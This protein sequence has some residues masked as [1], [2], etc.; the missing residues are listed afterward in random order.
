[1]PHSRGIARLGNERL[2]YTHPQS[3][4]AQYRAIF[5]HETYRFDLSDNQRSPFIIDCGAN[6]GVAVLYWKRLYPHATILTFEPDPEIAAVL[7]SNITA[8]GI[9]VEVNEAAVWTENG[10]RQFSRLGAGTGRFG[11][12]VPVSTVRLQD[13]LSEHVNLLK[14]DIEGAEIDVLTDCAQVLHN[15]DRIFVEFHSFVDRPQRLNILVDLLTSAGFRLFIET[16]F[17]PSPPFISTERHIDMDMQ[18]NIYARRIS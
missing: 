10:E 16:E 14:I 8:A 1:M 7:R 13:Y 6:I 4:A 15:I 17:C 12:G 9:N 3:L 11:D 5:Q 2:R 18:L